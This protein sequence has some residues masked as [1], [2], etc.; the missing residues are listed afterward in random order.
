MDAIQ[1][2]CR[3][4]AAQPFLIQRKKIST[5]TLT[6][7]YSGL[8]PAKT[9][10][11]EYHNF[12]SYRHGDYDTEM[13][14]DYYNSMSEF[15]FGQSG[16]HVA[17]F[18]DA[19]SLEDGQQFD[20]NFMMALSNSLVVTPLITPHALARMAHEDSVNSLDHLLL[21]WWLALTL[22]EIPGF[23]VQRIVPVFSGT[24]GEASHVHPLCAGC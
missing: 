13:A 15:A 4:A 19:K 17:V 21:E 7:H 23:P 20:V 2:H 5:K 11:G 22:Y 18:W 16:E 3:S 14:T 10:H 24:V 9:A 6:A 12:F 8:L 1:H